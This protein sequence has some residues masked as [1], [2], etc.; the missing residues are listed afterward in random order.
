ME[1]NMTM[2]FYGLQMH[3]FMVWIQIMQLKNLW[4]NKITPNLHEGRTPKFLNGFKCESK[5]K[6]TEKQGVG[7]RSL[8]R[9]TL[10]GRGACWSS[11]MGLGKVTS[12]NYSH[13]L[14]Q[15]QHKAVS[16]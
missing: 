12:I 1:V 13:R 2:D 15:N 16:A 10:R 8:A 6:A 9:S 4:K 11:K 3:Q 14:A 7:A 5:L